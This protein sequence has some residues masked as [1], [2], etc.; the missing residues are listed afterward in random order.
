MELKSSFQARGILGTSFVSDLEES[1]VDGAYDV[2]ILSSSW[3]NRCVSVSQRANIGAELVILVLPE[4]RDLLGLRE[5]N[6]RV[7]LEF[8]KTISKQVVTI[9][10]NSNMIEPFWSQI[11]ERIVLAARKKGDAVSVLVDASACPRYI[12]LATV[13]M[14][15]RDALCKRIEILYADAK[16][17]E[18]NGDTPLSF[19]GGSWRM[20]A[21][22]GL[23]GEGDPGKKRFYLVS[24]GFDGSRTMRVVS[25]ADPD[26]VS[27]FFP[28]PGVLPEYT[29]RA[30][31][32]NSSI[33][34]EFRIPESQL[35]KACPATITFT[36]RRQLKLTP[37]DNN[38]RGRFKG[39]SL[40]FAEGSSSGRRSR[41]EELPGA[42]LSDGGMVLPG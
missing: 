28:D 22:P 35:V 16:Y 39:D 32:E 40:S 24:V 12:T 5:R 34:E 31:K 2:V 37:S 15:F 36:H 20:L 10:G 30:Y 21:V 4:H 1:V 23:I 18:E 14:C 38:L 25:K 6:D 17:G 26:R 9:G 27:L 8:A 41:I 3:D 33:I 19:S 7:L 29:E 11:H 13:A 42:E